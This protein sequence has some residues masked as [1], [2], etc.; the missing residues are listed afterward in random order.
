[1]IIF[2]CDHP[3]PDLVANPQQKLLGMGP[4]TENCTCKHVIVS[5]VVGVVASF[6]LSKLVTY[7]VETLDVVSNIGGPEH[8]SAVSF[9]C[10][11]HQTALWPAAVG[12]AFPD[13]HLAF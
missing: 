12:A 4:G 2:F 9:F 13:S 3:L 1:M 8:C 10:L 7:Q 5:S 6:S 11:Y